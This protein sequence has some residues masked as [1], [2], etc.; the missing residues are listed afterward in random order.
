[1][2]GGLVLLDKEGR[3]MFLVHNMIGRSLIILAV[4]TLG[5]SAVVAQSSK[6]TV[7][8][9][10]DTHIVEV[11]S[12]GNALAPKVRIERVPQGLAET[13]KQANTRM[14]V[15]RVSGPVAQPVAGQPLWLTDES[16]ALTACQMAWTTLLAPP[17]WVIRCYPEFDRYTKFD[18]FERGRRGG[19]G[20][21]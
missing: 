7:H 6:V 1:M 18:R 16:G 15:P 19:W 21:M 4:T 20:R 10:S 5:A 13:A 9:G 3:F 11:D 2:S 12:Q 8:R 17:R 14:Y